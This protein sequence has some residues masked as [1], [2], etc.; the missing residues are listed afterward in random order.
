MGR[1]RELWG[2][3]GWAEAATARG[4]WLEVASCEGGGAGGAKILEQKIRYLD[5]EVEIKCLLQIFEA[6]MGSK[7][8]TSF[9]IPTEIQW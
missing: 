4:A 5:L 3:R 1:G 2:G 9:R 8:N 7:R 6:F